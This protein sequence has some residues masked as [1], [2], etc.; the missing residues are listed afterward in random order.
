[1]KVGGI[2]SENVQEGVGPLGAIKVMQLLEHNLH[3][4]P[5]GRAHGDEMK[6][7]GI[8][9]LIGRLGFKEMGHVRR[10]RAG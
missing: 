7:L 9:H 1:M 10:R 4:L 2:Q 6:A 3:L 8:L 5:I